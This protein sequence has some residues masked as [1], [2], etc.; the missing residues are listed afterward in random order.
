MVAHPNN[1][2]PHCPEW[3]GGAADP[4]GGTNFG[5]RAPAGSGCCR[6]PITTCSRA[7]SRPPARRLT[8]ARALASQGQNSLAKRLLEWRYALD[9]NSGATFA[10]IDAVIKDTE[11]QASP[12]PRPG[13]CAAPCRRAPRRRSLPSSRPQPWSPGSLPDAQFL[14][15]Q[16][17]AGRSAGGHRREDTRGRV[18][19]QRMG[20]GQL[21]TRHRTDDPA[22]MMPPAD[23]GKRS[24]PAGCPLLWRGEI[25]AAKRQV[26]RV[27][28]TMAE[29]GNARIGLNSYG[30]PKAQIAVDKVARQFRSQPAVRLVSCPANGRP[31]PRGPCDAAQGTRGSDG[32]GP[33]G[34]LV[35]GN[36]Y[37]GPRCPGERRSPAWRL[38]L[39]EHAGLAAGDQYAE[40]QFLAGFIALRFLKEPS[41]RWPRSEAGRRCR[42]PHPASRG[43]NIGR[44][45]P[46]SVGRRHC[47]RAGPLP[48]SGG[49]SGNLLWPDCPGRIDATPVPASERHYRRGGGGS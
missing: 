39:V 9:K 36:Q 29:I 1:P 42:P 47:R 8:V 11:S 20:R 32:Q 37:P 34:A 15:R 24:R 26:T 45:A 44:A 2:P 6:Q 33:C 31:R 43:P 46:M 40:Q 4:D 18:D 30:L 49:V 13:R 28:S 48:A 41:P 38:A 35:G 12:A 14:H 22:K 21:R 25:T 5:V 27:D 7:P 23:A 3:R 10:E 17:P 19:S 16:D